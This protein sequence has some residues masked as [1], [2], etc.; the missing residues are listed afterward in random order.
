MVM[1]VVKG[2]LSQSDFVCLQTP[3]RLQ[4]SP[5]SDFFRIWSER[6][7][8]FFRTW[9]IGSRAFGTLRSGELA[10]SWISLDGPGNMYVPGMGRFLV[11]PKD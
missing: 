7:R 5:K 10:E 2:G 3:M 1:V 9:K 6:F 8:N 4:V 11:I